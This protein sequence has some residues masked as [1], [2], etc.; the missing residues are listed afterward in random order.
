MA[1]SLGFGIMFAT[2][3][4]LLLVPAVYMIVEDAKHGALRLL[5]FVLR[6]L[7]YETPLWLQLLEDDRPAGE[8]GGEGGLVALE[9][10]VTG[11]SE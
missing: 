9:E 2:L 3:I 4:M 5:G 7:G 10:H 8:L 11:R 1:V 6:L